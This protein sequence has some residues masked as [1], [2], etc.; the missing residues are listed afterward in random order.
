MFLLTFELL[1]YIVVLIRN[2]ENIF[3]S[4][5]DTI[6]TLKRTSFARV[7]DMNVNNIHKESLNNYNNIKDL[8]CQDH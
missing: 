8:T 3:Y 4:K 5:S 6:I 1:F 7:D 2:L